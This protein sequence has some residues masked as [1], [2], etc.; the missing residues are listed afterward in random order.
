M[1]L[2][3][4]LAVASVWTMFGASAMMF[5]YLEDKKPS[6]IVLSFFTW[7]AGVARAIAKAEREGKP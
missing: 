6:R 2:N 4:A 1:L 3:V 5:A 7:P